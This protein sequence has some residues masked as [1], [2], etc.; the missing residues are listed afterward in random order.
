MLFKVQNCECIGLS[1][2]VIFDDIGSFFVKNILSSRRFLYFAKVKNNF[3]SHLQNYPATK[4]THRQ[5]F[6]PCLWVRIFV[7]CLSLFYQA[8]FFKKSDAVLK[9]CALSERERILPC[10]YL[11]QCLIAFLTHGIFAL[12]TL[13]FKDSYKTFS[14]ILQYHIRSARSGF[15]V[16]FDIDAFH[17]RQES[18]QKRMIENF[19]VIVKADAVTEKAAQFIRNGF[20]IATPYCPEEF[21]SVL[22]QQLVFK[23]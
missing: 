19:M 18:C 21:C 7:A 3:G 23:P 5:D 10:F 22:F 4:N 9:N 17:A 14:W 11:L 13:K 8:L 15:T 12:C 16:R 20:R 1:G 6:R 2:N